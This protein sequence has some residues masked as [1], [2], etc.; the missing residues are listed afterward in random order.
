VLGIDL[1]AAMLSVARSLK[2]VSGAGIRWWCGD[3]E[4]LPTFDPPFDAV[5]CQQGFQFFPDRVKATLETA[6][7]LRP[8]GSLAVSVWCGPDRN[9]LAAALI[10][11]LQN[12]GHPAFSEADDGL[13]RLDLPGPVHL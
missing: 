13:D 3:V 4:R 2:P 9:P 7:V 11:A 5:L 10:G 8:G 12:G 1:N 6:K